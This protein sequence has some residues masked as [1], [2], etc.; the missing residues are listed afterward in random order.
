[1]NSV[2]QIM[3]G[4][5]SANGA[6]NSAKAQVGAVLM[7]AAS[8]TS[9]S[10]PSAFR[11]LFNFAG[12]NESS[13]AVRNLSASM[14]ILTTAEGGL[15]RALSIVDRITDLAEQAKTTGGDERRALDDEVGALFQKLERIRTESRYNG[16]NVF[17]DRSLN[18]RAGAGEDDRIAY[19]LKGFEGLGSIAS[20]LFS[21]GGYT[22][23]VNNNGGGG[24]DSYQASA[25]DAWYG[26]LNI[27]PA[28]AFSS[29]S[30]AT[31]LVNNRYASLT[32]SDYADLKNTGGSTATIF[33][34]LS[35]ADG[36]FDRVRMEAGAIPEEL[37][38]LY[39]E[40]AF[41]RW[42]GL[43]GG[44][45]GPGG[46]P[47]GG[48]AEI[49]NLEAGESFG[50]MTVDGNNVVLLEGDNA[51]LTQGL[52]A[53]FQAGATLSLNFQAG[54]KPKS[55]PGASD[56]KY[57]SARFTVNLYAGNELVGTQEFSASASDT[58][59]DR[60]FIFQGGDAA[61]DGRM[62][63]VEIVKVKDDAAKGIVALDNLQASFDDGMGN[64]LPNVLYDGSFENIALNDGDKEK[65]DKAYDDLLGPGSVPWQSL[66]GGPKAAEAFDY[67]GQSAVYLEKDGGGIEQT[68]LSTFN[69]DKTYRV[70]MDLGDLVSSGGPGPGGGEAAANPN[71][72]ALY[73]VSLLAGD[74]VVG[75]FEGQTNNR[76]SLSGA[77][78]DFGG[79]GRTDLNGQA[80]TLRVEKIGGEALVVDNV[81]IGTVTTA[82]TG[83]GSTASW[84]LNYTD[85]AGNAASEVVTV[86]GANWNANTFVND[87]NAVSDR[88]GWFTKASDFTTSRAYALD[89]FGGSLGVSLNTAAGP[90]NFDFYN[91]STVEDV[92]D[93]VNSVSGSTGVRAVADGNNAVRFIT[94]DDELTLAVGAA[95]ATGA[96]ETFQKFVQFYRTDGQDGLSVTRNTGPAYAGPAD[97]MTLKLRDV[98]PPDSGGGD[99][100]ETTPAENGEDALNVLDDGRADF[101]LAALQQ[102]SAGL[103]E[104]LA[105][106]EGLKDVFEPAAETAIR[107][108][109]AVDESNPGEARALRGKT[110]ERISQSIEKTFEREKERAEN[111]QSQGNRKFVLELLK[112]AGLTFEYFNNSFEDLLNPA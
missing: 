24:G 49:Y 76:D 67:Q 57:Q 47:G 8:G 99:P 6:A 86:E 94:T 110:F 17:D 93:A 19:A 20:T 53:R 44:G 3:S 61:L 59:A 12:V 91:G 83:G 38:K 78:F 104:A 88:T 100:I 41:G 33:T 75:S 60:T 14:N 50:A 106:Y 77:T 34:S 109:K 51:A 31:V 11:N 39:E 62:L 58:S 13:L 7:A 30:A 46:G 56:P 36:D 27:D 15:E 48:D 64:T 68:L 45:P 63:S 25:L 105:Y 43:G 73:R 9:G 23:S 111:A 80:L 79:T 32:A 37:E 107:T 42:A 21:E 66:E 103:G 96:S 84:S 22:A 102:Y 89:E 112:Q 5:A 52:N 4:G 81:E 74:Q 18:F 26:A 85:S 92:L 2:G 16:I 87:V 29:T 35:M 90:S 10:D 40:S 71:A 101:T 28:S 98:P 82:N 97:T 72:G 54:I 108:E 1:M 55:G 95:G 69:A 70:R 65:V